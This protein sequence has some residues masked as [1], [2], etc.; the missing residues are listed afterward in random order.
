M[1]VLEIALSLNS[2]GQKVVSIPLTNSDLKV[3]MYEHSLNE[4]EAAGIPLAWRLVQGDVC[5]RGDK[6]VRVARLVR[7]AGKGDIVQFR[8]GCRT[9]LKTDNLTLSNSKDLANE[10]LSIRRTNQH[11]ERIERAT[12]EHKQAR[13]V[14]AGVGMS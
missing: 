1:R 7:K 12:I 6:K 14:Q 3:A 4:L 13:P 10:T 11:V 8:D 2:E 9:N 5:L